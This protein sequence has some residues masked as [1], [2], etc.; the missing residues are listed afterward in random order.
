MSVWIYCLT[1]STGSKSKNQ[2][3]TKNKS[4]YIKKFLHSKWNDQQSEK[5]TYGIEDIC[6]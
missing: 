5:A 6:K 1:K 2:N 3:Q 4:A